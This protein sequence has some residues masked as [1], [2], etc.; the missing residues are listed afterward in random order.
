[1]LHA[2][3]ARLPFPCCPTCRRPQPPRRCAALACASPADAVPRRALLLLGGA[4]SASALLY[5]APAPAAPAAPAYAAV[6]LGAGVYQIDQLPKVYQKAQ[7]ASYQARVEQV[8]REY[9]A[10][11]GLDWR[12]AVRLVFADAAAGGRDG[13]VRLAEELSRP[14]NAGLADTLKKVAGLRDAVAAS[15]VRTA[16]PLSWTDALSFTAWAATKKAFRDKLRA[17]IKLT[18]PTKARARRMRRLQCGRGER[19][20]GRRGLPDRQHIA[21]HPTPAPP[22][23]LPLPQ[24]LPPGLAADFP[25]PKVG[26]ADGSAP[27]A[28][29]LVPAPGAPVADWKA[30]FA[31]LGLRPSDLAVLGPTLLGGAGGE[32]GEAA[33]E[34]R[35]AADPDLREAVG[36]LRSSKDQL[37]RTTYETQFAASFAKLAALGARADPKAYLYAEAKPIVRL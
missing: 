37:A 26:S 18:D 17:Q 19:E 21:S 10:T 22:P 27:A 14:E 29:G 12:A 31:R 3:A 28:A 34:A 23:V 20:R 8:A 33:A 7:R 32:E 6:D 25:P 35:L 30:A 13:S 4:A 24:G 15:G 5:P 11:A 9:A 16:T 36:R 2:G 1:M